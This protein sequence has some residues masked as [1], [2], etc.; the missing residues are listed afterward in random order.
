MIPVALASGLTGILGAASLVAWAGKAGNDGLDDAITGAAPVERAPLQEAPTEPAP[1]EAPPPESAAA[2]QP[3]APPVTRLSPRSPSP[4]PEA[5]AN[6]EPIVASVDPT[7]DV[8]QEP[9]GFAEPPGGRVG[10]LRVGLEVPSGLPAD[11]TLRV[12]APDGTAKDVTTVPA[13][14]ARRR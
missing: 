12:T 1:V 3:D 9:T 10:T 14:R 8:A 5:S 2:G 13:R 11:A 4:P 6:P 7:S